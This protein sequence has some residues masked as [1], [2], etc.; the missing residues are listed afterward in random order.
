MQ[1]Q[2]RNEDNLK[3]TDLGTYREGYVQIAMRD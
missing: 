2:D 3:A 1:L